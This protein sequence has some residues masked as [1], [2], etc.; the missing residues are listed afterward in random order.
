MAN[1]NGRRDH[2]TDD[3]RFPLVSVFC[4]FHLTTPIGAS[5]CVS[6]ALWHSES[7][8]HDPKR[9]PLPHPPQ[10]IDVTDLPEPLAVALHAVVHALRR[11]L[12][13][14]SR[15]RRAAGRLLTKPGTVRG[16]VQRADLYDDVG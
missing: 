3:K 16:D 6:P 2:L 13:A 1:H 9:M 15:R 10:A 12:T 14:N 11:Q 5:S 8:T 4:W 7:M